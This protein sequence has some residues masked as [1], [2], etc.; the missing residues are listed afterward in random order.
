MRNERSY[1]AHIGT[2]RLNEFQV[3]CKR[4]RRLIRRT[5][6]KPAPDLKTECFQV[7]QTPHT[8]VERHIRGV[9]FFVMFLVRGLVPQKIPVRARR[10]HRR[11][12]LGRIF[13]ERKRY[14]A[15]GK[16]RSYLANGLQYLFKPENALAALQNKCT[17]S[18]FVT[19]LAAVQNLFFCQ[20]VAVARLVRAA[21]TAIKAVVFAQIAYLDKPSDKDLVF[22]YFASPFI[23]KRCR[24]FGKFVSL[25]HYKVF[26]FIDGERMF[27]VKSVD[28]L[29]CVSHC[30]LRWNKPF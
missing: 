24:I 8:V 18:E 4:F 6:H 9:Q 19:R 16:S 7:F 26:V 12:S 28:E 27:A 23:R 15:V 10:F 30:P 1:A 2:E 14:R 20:S 5:D 29:F 11:I 25:R 21:Y 13:A 17:E 22:I 3:F